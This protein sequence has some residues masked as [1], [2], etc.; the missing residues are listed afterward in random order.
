MSLRI[1]VIMGESEA[2]KSTLIGH[3]T[4]QFGKSDNGLKRNGTDFSNVP[5][6]GGGLLKLFSMRC[7]LQENPRGKECPVGALAY[8][9]KKFEKKGLVQHSN[10][11]LALRLNDGE[12]QGAGFEYLDYFIGQ[13]DVE[14]MSIVTLGAKDCDVD[15]ALE[16]GIPT[17]ALANWQDCQRSILV[18]IAAVRRHFGWA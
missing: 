3:L 4:G 5:L 10:C 7:A 17:L 2:G 11:L 14:V 9:R 8:I 6:S 18:S 12:G 1:W 15:K 13:G 16:Y